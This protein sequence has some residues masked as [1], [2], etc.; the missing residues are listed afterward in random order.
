MSGRIILTEDLLL[1]QGDHKKTYIDP[2][3]AG[4][5][6]KVPFVTPDIDLRRELHYRRTREKRNLA[7]CLLT[8]YY[9]TVDT[10]L[11]TGYV[12]ERIT[13]FD[14]KVSLT[15]GD[16]FNMAVSDSDTIPYLEKAMI[17]FRDML[18]QE[19]IVISNVEAANFVVQRFSETDFTI[20]IIDNIGTPVKIPLAYYFDVVARKRLKKYWKRFLDELQE[21]YPSVMTEA[22]KRRLLQ[23][24]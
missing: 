6:I 7:S 15:I 20:R 12:F 2:R 14:G 23:G 4:R 17:C 1:G 13:D 5:C 3:D 10:N 18:F 24:V 9:G 11:G 16:L 22:M 8:E 19:L 21:D